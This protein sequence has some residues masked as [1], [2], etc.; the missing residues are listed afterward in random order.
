MINTEHK[1]NGARPV[2]KKLEVGNFEMLKIKREK[3][4]TSQESH[5]NNQ[6]RIVKNIK[7]MEQIEAIGARN[8]GVMGKNKRVEAARKEKM[9]KTTGNETAES[10]PDKGIKN[11]KFV[12]TSGSVNEPVKDEAA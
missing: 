9:S 7:I 8:V 3:V 2:V 12:I 1:T 5:R 6:S 10:T 4:A 11:V